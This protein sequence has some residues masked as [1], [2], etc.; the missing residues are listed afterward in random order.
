MEEIIE[1]PHE[2]ALLVATYSGAKELLICQEHLEELSFLAQT[3]GLKTAAMLPCASRK[4]NA[5]TFVSK[6]NLEQ[7]LEACELH[8]VSLVIFDEEISPAQQRNLEKHLG[9]RVIDRSE[10]ILGVFGQR[11]HSKEAKLQVELAQVRYESP[12]LRRLWTHLSRETATGGT[13]AFLRSAGEK[14]IEIDRRLLKK[15]IQKLQNRLKEVRAH[16]STQRQAR[17][18]SNIPTFAL[19]G[20]TNAGKSTLLNAL[21]NAG[22]FTEDKLFATLDT[23]TRQF[24]L[25]N[26]QKILLIDTVGFI[27]K[28]PHQLIAAFKST[29]DEA[30]QADIL[31]HVIDTSHHMAEEQAKASFDVLK[32][33]KAHKKPIITILNKIDACT[34][35]SLLTRLRF[36][37]P[38]TV[39]IS[40]KNKTGLDEL[41]DTMIDEINKQR[42]RIHLSIPQSEYGKVCQAFNK[43]HLHSI[44]YAEN[45]VLLEIDL[46]LEIV[47][48]LEKYI[49]EEEE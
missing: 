34:D 29:L 42:R 9:R 27:R 49:I 38:K 6:G 4:I 39:Q 37:Y 26:N 7:I 40:A 21:T 48:R 12:R 14:Q 5:S 28:L 24:S 20:Y 22:V 30:I 8:K 1:I 10:L 35:Q 33:L 25:T 11:A 32:E 16:R 23:T 3:F 17:L 18:R 13:G 45:N 15:R 2:A 36:T 19:V 46:P 44:D 47:G 43:G 41:V 31:L